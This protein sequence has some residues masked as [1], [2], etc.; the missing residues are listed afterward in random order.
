[1]KFISLLFLLFAFTALPQSKDPD[2]IIKRLK[3]NFNKVKD[4]EVDVKIKVDMDFIKV[5]ESTAKIYYKNPDKMHFE[6]ETFAMIPREG[7]DFS[8]LSLL[9][10]NWSAFYQRE[11][12][13]DGHKVSV[14]KVIPLEEH[15]NVVLSTLW[16][17][18]QENIIRKVESTTKMN[19]TFTIDLKYGNNEK[20]F[21]LPQSMTFSFNVDRS[22][23]PEMLSDVT[24]NNTNKKKS[25]TLSGKVYLQY[26][27]YKIN[28]GIPDSIFDKKKKK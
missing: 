5:P 28:Q 15:A 8:P 1:M 3:D 14:V 27:N 12:V 17:D 7:M 21:G 16:I 9:K 4:Y 13:I 6:S 22:K 26:G 25:R 24:D 19:G 23:A 18:Q 20:D 2:L 10:G 11:D